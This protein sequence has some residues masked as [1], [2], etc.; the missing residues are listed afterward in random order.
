[1]TETA[2]L[3]AAGVGLAVDTWGSGPPVLVLHG[4]TG[5][6]AAMAPLTSRLEGFTVIVPDL[7]GLEAFTSTFLRGLH[8]CQS[9]GCS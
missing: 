2:V 1:M 6:A 4:F 3:A 5:S 8:R 9:L 7:V